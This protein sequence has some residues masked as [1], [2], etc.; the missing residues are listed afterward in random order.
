MMASRVKAA[1]LVAVSKTVVSETNRCIP[2][3]ARVCGRGIVLSF[4]GRES[5]TSAHSCAEISPRSILFLREAVLQPL[6]RSLL[7]S[8]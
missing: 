1:E 6:H 5:R 8:G 2:R 4:Q 7:A 3:E